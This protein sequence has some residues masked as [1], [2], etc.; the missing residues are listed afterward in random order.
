[1]A[2]ETEGGG[3][4][5]RKDMHRNEIYR[6]TE[7]KKLRNERHKDVYRKTQTDID[8]ETARDWLHERTVAAFVAPYSACG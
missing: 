3:Q 1:M 2:A 5:E 7:R 8:A 6:E 4:R